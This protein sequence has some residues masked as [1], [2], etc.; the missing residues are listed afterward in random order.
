ME[1]E[2]QSMCQQDMNK[3][4]EGLWEFFAKDEVKVPAV[5]R[6]KT[7]RGFNH[8]GTAHAL[9]PH[10]YIWDFDNDERYAHDSVLRCDF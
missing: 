5:L 1:M 4:K 7:G 10:A 8:P 6:G 3:L 9:C 2:S